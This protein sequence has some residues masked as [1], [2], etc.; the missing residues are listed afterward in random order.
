MPLTLPSGFD[1][2][3]LGIHP[4]V[5]LWE[6]SE[7]YIYFSRT[8]RW[9]SSCVQDSKLT[10]IF[11]SSLWK[12]YCIVF[13]FY[14]CQESAFSLNFILSWWS[15]I[16]PMMVFE[17]YILFM[18]LLWLSHF[19]LFAPPP[20]PSTSYS[21]RPSSHHCS[22]PWVTHRS[23]LVTPFP[24]LYFTSPWLVCTYHS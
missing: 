9:L 14:C 12:Y 5:A 3:L 24:V 16:F 7:S 22:R 10:V 2:P 1:F 6:T 21:L 17:N 8:V 20:P 15:F 13:D 23:S 19:S 4:L 18:M 11:P